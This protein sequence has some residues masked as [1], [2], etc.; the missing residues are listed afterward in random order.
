M[1]FLILI[2]LLW[3][4]TALACWR[5]QGEV[6]LNNDILKID[7]KVN[8][9]QT[10]SFGKGPYLINLKVNNEQILDV[11]LLNREKKLKM[12]AKTKLSLEDGEK[13]YIKNAN[14]YFNFKLVN[15]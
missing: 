8:H 1:K 7:Q 14:I 9:D 3:A 10:Y 12:V 15:I 6:H 13:G 5:L 2:L 4:Q 11:E